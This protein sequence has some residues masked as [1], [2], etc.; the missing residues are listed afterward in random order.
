M[1]HSTPSSLSDLLPL[2]LVGS[3]AS[4]Q[5]CDN[6]LTLERIPCEAQLANDV[7]GNVTFNPMSLF[8]VALSCFQQVVEL[9]RVKLLYQR[10]EIVSGEKHK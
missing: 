3:G 8:G 5:P 9:L 7:A 2:E 6:M 1:S 4:L 10:R